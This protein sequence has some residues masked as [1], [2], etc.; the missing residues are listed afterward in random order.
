M[1]CESWQCIFP[2]EKLDKGL[3]LLLMMTSSRSW[4][5]SSHV[6]KLRLVQPDSVIVQ[7]LRRLDGTRLLRS[8]LK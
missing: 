8:K 4:V 2:L 5:H 1:Q 3:L 6:F 7:R